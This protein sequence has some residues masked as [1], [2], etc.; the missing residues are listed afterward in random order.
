MIV[1]DLFFKYM[2]AMKVL[3]SGPSDN[4][5]VVIPTYLSKQSAGDVRKVVHENIIASLEK[6]QRL[7]KGRYLSLLSL[8]RAS[9]SWAFHAARG[10]IEWQ[11]LWYAFFLNYGIIHVLADRQEFSV[12][13]ELNA[14]RFGQVVPLVLLLTPAFT[15]IENFNGKSCGL[16]LEPA[17]DK[18]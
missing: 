3:W 16:I 13:N 2:T 8:I 7:E 6:A 12:T 10:T 9:E 5:Y 18:Y 11:L 1:L 15:I 17:T 14:P 4:L